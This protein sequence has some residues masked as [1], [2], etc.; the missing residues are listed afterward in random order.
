MRGFGYAETREIT[1]KECILVRAVLNETLRLFCPLHGS[2]R[3]SLDHG[4]ILPASDTTYNKEPMYLPPN[5][6]VFTFPLLLHRNEAL[7][8]PDAHVYDP[9]RW[10]DERL[11]RV[12]GNPSIYI[13]F[14]A[15][16]RNVSNPT[17]MRVKGLTT[18]YSAL[19]RTM[20]T[21]RPRCS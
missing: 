3:Q 14:G 10:L 20:L 18:V 15:G 7:W 2:I 4:V 8:G 5:S 17:K 6:P 9:D 1:E 11:Q 12:I 13:P 16:P 21:T 19:A